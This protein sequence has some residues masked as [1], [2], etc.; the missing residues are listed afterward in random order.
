VF[1]FFLYFLTHN[2]NFID[3]FTGLFAMSSNSKWIF[4]PIL[5]TNFELQQLPV[6][7]ERRLGLME[8]VRLFQKQTNVGWDCSGRA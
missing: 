5:L 3:F 7:T 4:F 2:R 6:L 8:I 1:G